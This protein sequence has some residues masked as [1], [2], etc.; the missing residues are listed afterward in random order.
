METASE[1]IPK[2]SGHLNFLVSFLVIMMQSCLTC[3]TAVIFLASK[4]EGIYIA[5]KT[6]DLNLKEVVEVS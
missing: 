4:Q 1:V 2:L 6:P 3:L 5:V